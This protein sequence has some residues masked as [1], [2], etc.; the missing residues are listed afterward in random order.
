MS[1]QPT[2][3]VPL[4]PR[5]L[6]AIDMRSVLLGAGVFVLITLP[7]GIIASALA[8][9]DDGSNWL[10]IAAVVVA[11]VAPAVAG[12]VAARGQ[13]LNPLTHGAVA[14][15]VGWLVVAAISVVAKL[16]KGAPV[17]GP[18]LTLL[19]LGCVDVCLGIVGAYF[20]FRRELRGPAP[21][22]P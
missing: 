4:A 13:R 1:T 8:G 6:A 16:A 17:A 12:A 15:A 14:T 7:T 2:G 18:L 10:L 5:G 3:E 22:Q 21:P 19:L 9:D 11:I 20:T